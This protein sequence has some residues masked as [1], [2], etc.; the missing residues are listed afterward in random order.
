[1][2]PRL[3]ISSNRAF[4]LI[5]LSVVMAVIAILA[6]LAI[7]VLTSITERA[8]VVQDLNNL[9][10][11]GVATQLYLNDHDGVLFVTPTT[12]PAPPAATW[13]SLLHPKYLPAWKILQSPFDSRTPS[14]I[15]ASAR[16]SYGINAN[17]ILGTSVDKITNPSVFILFA[18]TQNSGSA[19]PYFDGGA[20]AAV[21]V[22]RDTSSPGGQ[23]V[24]GTHNKRTRINVGF[25]DLHVE[26]IT[27]ATFKAPVD[28]ADPS[29]VQRWS[30]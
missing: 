1:M 19:P 11:I 15:D 30:P 27:W 4:T 17:G 29:S 12:P 24:G 21:T 14:E 10:Q 25:G 20:A 2:V 8:R 26:N 7:P 18:P 22:T 9:R 3:R 23:P 28:V 5:E 6:T 16:I 13:M